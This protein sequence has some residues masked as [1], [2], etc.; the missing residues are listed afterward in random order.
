MSMAAPQARLLVLCLT[1]VCLVPSAPDGASAQAFAAVDSAALKL[2]K[3]EKKAAKRAENSATFY[4]AETPMEMSLTANMKRIKS[5]KSDKAPWR[6]ATV[7]FTDT[8]GKVVS[9]PTLI[10]TRGIWRLKNCDIPPLRLNFKSEE[11]KGT[12]LRGLNKPKLVSACRND[13]DF[14]QYVIEEMQLYRIYGLLTPAS[15]RARLLRMNYTDSASGKVQTTGMAIMLEEPEVLAARM[16]GEVVKIKG[17]LP[18]DLS[19][20]HDV[21]ASLFEYMIGNTD[22]SVYALHNIDL[23]RME[24]GDHM[25]I[26][27]D[28]DFSGVINAP[29]ATVDP[30]LPIMHVRDRL[31]RGYCHDPQDFQ[32]AFALFNEKKPEIYALYSDSIGSKLSKGTVKE[33]LKYFDDFYETI[34]NPKR[35]QREIFDSCLK[36]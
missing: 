9:I 36:P 4:S 34:N 8:S 12:L 24:N 6:Q 13:E 33:T 3:A 27:Y 14:E 11:T 29:Y 1:A 5:D 17:A 15:H 23:V 30:K 10:K 19:T 16:N 26:P 28:F 25:P 21:L 7:S 31:Y 20:E 2:Q 32:K 35:A 18:A 22:W